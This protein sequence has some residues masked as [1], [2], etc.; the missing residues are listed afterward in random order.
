MN[1]EQCIANL[2]ETMQ[3]AIDSGD[4]KVDGACD[5][6]VFMRQAEYVLRSSGWTQNAIDG[7]WQNAG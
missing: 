1:K 3:Q 5:P 2:L 4:W 6:D 7:H